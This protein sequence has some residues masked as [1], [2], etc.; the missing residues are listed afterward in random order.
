MVFKWNCNRNS[1][2]NSNS[3]IVPKMISKF[4]CYEIVMM[5]LIFCF[6]NQLFD[7][8]FWDI[9]IRYVTSSYHEHLSALS[10]QEIIMSCSVTIVSWTIHLVR[11]TSCLVVFWSNC[12]RYFLQNYMHWNW[13]CLENSC[14]KLS[15]IV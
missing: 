5:H 2:S 6:V 15:E 1:C 3:R 13:M 12:I 9:L 7:D 8:D 10:S 11:H 14:Q 4:A